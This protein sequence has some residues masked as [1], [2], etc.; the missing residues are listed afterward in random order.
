[1]LNLFI[2]RSTDKC[3][4]FYDTLKGIKKF[5]WTEEC[6]KAFQ[7]LKRYLATPP[8]LAKPVEGEPL[9]MYIAVSVTAV[10]GVLIREERSDKTPIFNVRKTLLDAE[11]LYPMME[12][13]ALAVV[14]S[15]RKLRPYFQ[16]HRIVVLTSFPLRTILHSPSQSGRLAKWAIDLSEYDIEYR[17]KSCAK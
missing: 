10:S 1:M 13:L 12:K 15:A 16:S 14:M 2:S 7:Q 9:F 8:V 17:A 11:T 3:L 4:P 5:E 6:E